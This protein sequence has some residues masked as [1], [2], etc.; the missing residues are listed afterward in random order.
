MDPVTP[1]EDGTVSNAKMHGKHATEEVDEGYVKTE[2]P[3]SLTINYS[4]AYASG[5]KFNYKKM[6]Y[7]MELTNNLSLSGSLGLGQG[8]KVSASMS[9]DFDYKRVTSCNFNVSRDLH[10]WSMTAS[11][12]PIGPFRS[13]TFHI[14]VNASILADLK[15]DKN[16]YSSSNSNVTWW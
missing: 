1:N 13:Y 7:N 4:L 15:Y 2:F 10:C 3:W 11:F 14:G 9:Y 8:W 16:G 12:N 5:G 6:Y